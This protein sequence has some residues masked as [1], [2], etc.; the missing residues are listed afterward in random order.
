[1]NKGK[2]LGHTDLGDLLN[3]EVYPALFACLDTA[4]PEFGWRRTGNHWVATTWP[5]NFPDPANERK[6]SRLMVYQDRPYWIKVHGHLGVRFL[7]YVNGGQNPT[8]PDFPQ[9]VR[10]L[11]EK[12]G[13][14]SPE[15]EYTPEE[16]EKEVQRERRKSALDAVIGHCQ[17]ALW[18]GRGTS[19]RDY[20]VRERGLTEEGIKALGLGL[21]TSSADISAYL[22]NAGVDVAD[23]ALLWPKLEGYI[24]FPW[25]DANGQPLTLYGRWPG[26]PPEGLP[27]TIA[28]PGEGTK[29]S[30]L[31]FDRTR[32]AH[33]KDLILV[34]GVLDAAVLQEKGDSRVM[35][36]VAAQL[37]GLQVETLTR[38]RVASVTICLDP[39]GGGERGTL[40]CIKS[41]HE[42]GIAAYVAPTLPDGMDPDQFV[43]KH[44]MDAWKAHVGR[45]VHALRYQAEAIV[46]KHKAG[47]VWTDAG[48]VAALDEAIAFDTATKDPERL[49]ALELFFWPV[50]KEATGAGEEALAARRVAAREKRKQERERLGYESL[51]RTSGELLRKGDTEGAKDLLRDEVERLRAEER[52]WKADPVLSVKEELAAHALAL[53]KWR[54]KEFIGLPQKTLPELDTATLGF[55]GLML[56]AAGP[57]V[58]KTALSVQFG[59][60]VVK[61]NEDACFLFLSLEMSRTDIISRMKCRLAELDWKTLVF[62]SPDRRGLSRD[63]Y[64]TQD[65]HTRLRFA[66]L[67]LEELGDRIRVLDER[68]FPAPTIENVVYQVKDLKARTG[69]SRAFLLVDYLQV[70]PIPPH[71]S[72]NL[73]NDLDADKWRIGAMKTLRDALDGDAVMVISEARKPGGSTTGAEWGGELSDVMGAARG[74]YTPDMVFLL[75]PLR[76]EDLF[77]AMG[78]D[79]PKTNKDEE[80][81]EIRRTLQEQGVSWNTLKIA[82]GRDGVLRVHL[83]LTFWFRQSRFEEGFKRHAE[84]GL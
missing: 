73:R 58:G 26:K 79:V 65:E 37:S 82:K 14:R 8:G 39:D 84:G 52:T 69:T 36:C 11:C 16:M 48:R 70:W 40:S 22:Q 24:I 41:L 15:R 66:D 55:R 71:E 23:T 5:A 4:F 56:L 76:N 46:R 50:I 54:G 13:V 63:V 74:T 27:K 57:N 43:I 68:N 47:K 29:A 81:A 1:M 32:Q 12:C 20:L 67:S 17:E 62:G 30:P 28:L 7:D 45:K 59:L 19:A 64:F 75:N 6:P 44:G 10:S 3:H 83:D 34:E 33:H 38:H 18:S 60:D 80:A 25:A 31:Y 42:A 49:P 61:Y 9:A 72:Q 35:A 51:V 78:K 21:Y 77:K 2:P 53:E